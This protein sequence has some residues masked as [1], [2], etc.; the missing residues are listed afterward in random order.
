MNVSKLEPIGI[1]HSPYK[2]RQEAPPQGN[3]EIS[4]IEVFPE[5]QNGLKDVDAFSHLHILYWLHDSTGYSL[6][7]KTPWDETPHGLFATRTPNRPNPIGHS[8]VKL[9]GRDG[10][11]L[12][13]QGL[14]AIDGTPVVDIKPYVRAIDSKPDAGGGWLDDRAR[15]FK[16]KVYEYGTSTQWVGEKEGTLVAPQRHRVEVGCP[17]EFGGKPHYWT[18]EHLFVASIEVCVMTTFLWLVGKE[19]YGIISYESEAVGK[20]Q[21][22]GDGFK[23]GEVEIRPVITVT[24]KSEIDK[25]HQLLQSANERCLIS[26]SLTCEVVLN[27]VV[28][29][30]S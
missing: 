28:K 7:V 6:S 29:E 10:N 22:F 25:I 5:F 15:F 4:M 12:R 26:K 30:E 3:D 14:D 13:V 2:E 1:I 8:V 9:M 11:V 24:D 27:A 20:A 16:P 19:G 23:F 18:P 21:M 17:P